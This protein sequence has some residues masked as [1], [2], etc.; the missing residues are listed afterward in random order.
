MRR[1]LF[2]AASAAAL[3]TFGCDR[4]EISTT[5]DGG[6][7]RANVQAGDSGTTRA[8]R[9]Y[10]AS[11]FTAQADGGM[12]PREARTASHLRRDMDA[13]VVSAMDNDASFAQ[14]MDASPSRGSV[15]AR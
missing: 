8:S 5:M 6:S 11:S 7:L 3:A 13:G 12:P 15:A 4:A 1:L 2:L 14:A 9:D 10:D